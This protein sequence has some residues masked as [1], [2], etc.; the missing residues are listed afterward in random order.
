M[1][2]DDGNTKRGEFL[3][4][5]ITAM[6]TNEEGEFELVLG[7]KQ[8]L[9]VFFLIVLLLAVFFSMG[10]LAGRYTAPQTTATAQLPPISVDPAPPPI[11]KPPSSSTTPPVTQTEPPPAPTPAKPEPP[12]ATKAPPTPAPVKPEP[13][14]P[15]PAKPPDPTPVAGG[16]A[17]ARGSY[18]QVAATRPPDAVKLSQTLGQKGYQTAQMAVPNSD[19]V[20]VLVGPLDSGAVAQTKAKLKLDGYDSIPRAIN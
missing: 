12:V 20:R 18:L 8:L 2:M 7:N 1:L 3:K 16:G 14:K 9:S 13:P 17:L 10:Y 5:S 6:P 15:A 19:L 4:E 11:D